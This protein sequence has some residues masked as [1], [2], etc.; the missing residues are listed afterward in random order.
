MS[1]VTIAASEKAFKQL[2]TVVRDNFTFAKSDSASFGPFSAEY[3]VAAHLE[4]GSIQL[5]NDGTIEIS[6]LDVVWDTLQVKVCFNIPGFCIPGFCVI[7]DP[8]NGCLVGI[9]EICIGGPICVPLDLSGLVSEVSKFRARLT[10]KYFVDPGR[11]PG[12]SDLEAEFNGKSNMWQVFIDPDLVS[13]DP[14]DVPAS[15]ANIFENFVEN[16][17]RNGLPGPGFIKDAIMWL[18]GPVIDL[19]K[20]GL[21]ILDDLEDFVQNLLGIHFGI[22]G[23]I[24]TAVADY[25]ANKYP[26]YEFEDPYPI[27][28]QETGLIPVKI[29]LRKLAAT[30]N[31]NEMIVTGDVGAP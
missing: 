31:T 27:L 7:P 25:F 5:N 12:W 13:V 3:A 28:P 11:L 30:V 1:H 19:I 21:D 6:A 18:I 2:F 26:I 4:N 29:P 17:I 10:T 24:Q 20:S 16:A 23:I 15:I 14:V 9:P 22:F 8:W